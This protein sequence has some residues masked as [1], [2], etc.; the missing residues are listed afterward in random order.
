MKIGDGCAT[1][2]D[3][4]LPRPLPADELDGWEGGSEVKS[5][6][7]ISVALRSSAGEVEG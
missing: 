2:T 7:R 6:V 3:Y 1:V 4:K 5:E